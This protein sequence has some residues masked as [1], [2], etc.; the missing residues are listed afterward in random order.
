MSLR[1]I[2]IVLVE[3]QHP[4]NIGAVARAM[5]TMALENLVLVAPRD[6]PSEEANA[7]ASGAHDVLER[8]QVVETLGDAVGDCVLV[9]GT[10][11][12]ERAHPLPIQSARECAATIVREARADAPAAILFGPERTGLRSQDMHACT[13]HVTIPANPDYA[14]LNLGSAVQLIGYEVFLASGEAPA[15]AAREVEYPSQGDVE[16]F[17]KHLEDVLVSREFTSEEMRDAAHAKLRRVFGRARPSVGE[18]KMLHS[19]VKLMDRRED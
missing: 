5:K 10:T 1:D 14:S 12:R 8:A 2:R 13:H 15:V 9:F 19:L 11:S 7:R 17:Y 6:Y 3:P 4:G 18:L 16:F